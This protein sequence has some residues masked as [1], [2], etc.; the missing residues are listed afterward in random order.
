M[1]AA[2]TSRCR[3]RTQGKT[4]NRL[5]R[6]CREVLPFRM[7]E[8]RRNAGRSR[9]PPSSVCQQGRSDEARDLQ[10]FLLVFRG[11]VR[12]LSVNS[13]WSFVPLGDVTKLNLQ[14]DPLKKDFSSRSKSALSQRLRSSYPG[15][16]PPKSRRHSSMNWLSGLRARRK[17]TADRSAIRRP[18]FRKAKRD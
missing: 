13:R 18:N 10:T 5:L 8:E 17:G 2:L 6:S 4:P 16:R 11:S 12:G 14:Y 15:P 1:R 3:W 7:P 9:I